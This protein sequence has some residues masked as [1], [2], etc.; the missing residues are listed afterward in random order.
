[1]PSRRGILLIF[2]P[3]VPCVPWSLPAP[4]HAQETR[5]ST[6]GLPARAQ[7]VLP[8]SELK[9]KRPER[10]DPLVL[11]IVSVSPHGAAFRY[12]FEYYGLEKG[13]FDLRD[14]LRRKDGSSTADLRPIPAR[15]ESVLPPGQVR[16]NDLQPAE[17]PRPGGYWLALTVGGALWVLGLLAILFI[18]RRRCKT[19]QAV[20]RPATVADR[21]RPLIEGAMAGKLGPDRLA[22]LERGLILFWSRRL[23]LLDRK[24]HEALAELRHHP[25]AGPLLAQLEI[26]LHRPSPLA[27]IDVAALLEPYRTAPADAFDVEARTP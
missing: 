13:T 21:L 2:F 1:M 19:L 24:P 4:L 23:G 8:G 5:V 18:G 22:E 25:E 27:T 7:L 9:V 20:T 16:P 26:W 17:T 6:V 3:C 12:E 11:R 14:Y 10:K 15:I